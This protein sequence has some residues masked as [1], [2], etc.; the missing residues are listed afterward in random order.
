MVDTV[1]TPDAKKSCIFDM[2]LK[3]V[4]IKLNFTLMNLYEGYLIRKKIDR[5]FLLAAISRNTL[6]LGNPIGMQWVPHEEKASRFQ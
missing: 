3:E 6:I 2:R 1:S 5:T 4:A